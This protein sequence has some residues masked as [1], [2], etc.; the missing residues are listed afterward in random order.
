[1]QEVCFSDT[2]TLGADPI[3]G[4]SYS[5]SPA[6][7][8]SATDIA[9]PFANP[10]STTTYTLTVSDGVCI[11]TDQV[12]VTVNSFPANLAGL[13][14]LICDGGGVM[15][16]RDAIPNCVYVWS[17]ATN[18]SSTTIAQPIV[19]SANNVTYTVEVTDTTN[20]CSTRDEVLVDVKGGGLY[21]GISPN[22]DGINDDWTIPMLDCYPSNKVII[23]NRYGAEVWK[24]TD[25]NNRDNKWNGRNI[26]GEALPDGTY[27]YVIAYNDTEKRGWVFIKR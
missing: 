7:G 8:L 20:G 1:D 4:Y 27:Y 9:N 22:G 10:L 2:C 3:I 18:I 6:T 14:Q 15:L 12:V 19:M 26:N 21:N 5:W 24:G 16:G 13:D 25:Y 11:A 23:L 17:P